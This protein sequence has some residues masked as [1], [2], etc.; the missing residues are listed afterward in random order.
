LFLVYGNLKMCEQTIIIESSAADLARKGA[1][2]FSKTARESI[3]ARG[4]F[5]VAISGGSTPRNMHRL[6]GKEPFVSDIQWDKTDIFWVDERCVPVDDKASNYGTAKKDF[7]NKIPIPNGH[8]H[9]MPVASSPEVGALLYQQELMTYFKPEGDE[10]T[11][12][13]L[14]YLGIGKDGHTASLFPGQSS[15]NEREKWV[16]A[17]KGGRPN[18]IRLTMTY[19]LLNSGKQIVF[20]ASGREK[21]GIV[22]KVLLDKK[23][24]LPAQMIQPQKGMLLWLLDREAASLLEG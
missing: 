8:I 2:I 24:R 15:L 3:G 16:V 14:I 13:D 1:E 17:V 18:A 21:A 11:L 4:H 10:F 23:S 12:F 6:L 7:L 5:V 9:P 22:K 19:P 20:L